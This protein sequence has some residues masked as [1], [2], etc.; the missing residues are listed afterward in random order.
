MFP[1]RIP[2]FFA[3]R[4]QY[5]T[6]NLKA[7][8]FG[9]FE[10]NLL[11]IP[12]YCI[13]IINLLVI[14]RVSEKINDRFLLGTISQ[15]WV[16]PLLIA[17]ECLP[18]TRNHW[19]VW[20]LSILVYA[21]PYIHAVLVSITSRNA[22]TVRTRTVASAFYNMCVQTANIIG[23]QVYRTPDKP[24]YYTGNKVLIGI[25]CYNI[26]LFVGAKFYY[27]AINK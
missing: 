5:L 23:N 25:A 27:K 13:F 8:G 15:I 17:L 12:A 22:G 10:T 16:L 4:V 14:T 9:T 19:T 24:T 1:K 21:Q 3:D 11:C 20:A 7:A 26:V 18:A 6:L 2:T